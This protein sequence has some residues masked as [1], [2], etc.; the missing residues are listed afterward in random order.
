MRV[1]TRVITVSEAVRYTMRARGIRDEKLVTV[2]NGTIGTPRDQIEATLPRLAGAPSVLFVGGL[3]PRKGV[4]D[5]LTAFEAVHR[6]FPEA[7]LHI[8]GAG[9]HASDYAAQAAASNARD[10]VFFH[11]TQS[12]P[13]GWMRASD[14][15]VLPSLEEPAGLVLSE[16]REAGCAVI[17]TRTGGIP[18]M[19]NGG[20]AGLLVPP[21]AEV[22]CG[23]AADPDQLALWQSNSGIGLEHLALSRVA[24]ETMAVYKSAIG[25]LVRT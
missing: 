17:G 18:E 12:H 3:H 8:V 20:S 21:L 19:L 15:F 16:A 1:G 2:L 9:P 13:L 24:N 22:I 25:S 10:A 23:L 7:K 14:I 6:R 11:G 4:P 5:L